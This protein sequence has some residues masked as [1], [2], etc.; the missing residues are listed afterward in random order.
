MNIRGIYSL[1][2]E[3]LHAHRKL[4]SKAVINFLI[5]FEKKIKIAQK[6]YS[7]SNIS[8]K[9]INLFPHAAVCLFHL[10]FFLVALEF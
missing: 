5:S 6:Y 4:S 2:N 7:L 8:I 9:F 3:V 10:I 1:F